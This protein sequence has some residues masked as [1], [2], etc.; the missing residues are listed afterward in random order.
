MEDR[1]IHLFLGVS[2]LVL[3][4]WMLLSGIHG[5]SGEDRPSGINASRLMK[6]PDNGTVQ[7]VFYSDG[8]STASLTLEVSNT[9]EERSR[10]LMY[11]RSL[12]KGRGMLF[13]WNSS[14]KRG[15]WMKNTYIP[16]DMIF[17]SGN[18][19]VLNVEK[20]EPQPNTSERNLEI[21][22]SEGPAQFVIETRKGFSAT[23]SIEEG[24]RIRFRFNR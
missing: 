3:G 19:T 23:H 18:G 17:V 13:V 20:A 12:G 1:R 11:R 15:F 24:T 16:L 4:S 7:A 9:P 6:V 10:G 2:M 22:R 14:E 21:Y 8:R 5:I